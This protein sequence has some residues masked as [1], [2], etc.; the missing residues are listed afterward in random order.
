MNA[1]EGYVF[2]TVCPGITT[3]PKFEVQVIRIEELNNEALNMASVRGRSV[4]DIHEG[5][6]DRARRLVNVTSFK[7]RL[8]SGRAVMR[9]S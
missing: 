3:E 5:E 8:V 9:H 1:S 7:P 2:D 6:L 4:C